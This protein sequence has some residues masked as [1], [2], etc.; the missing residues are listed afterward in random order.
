MALRCP[1][2][3][4]PDALPFPSEESLPPS[5]PVVSRTTR[6]FNPI[7]QEAS[8]VTSPTL[9]RP[10]S[11]CETVTALPP[12]L[13]D[14]L[15]PSW[16]LALSHA[17]RA[18]FF[19]AAEGVGRP[20]PRGKQRRP[21]SGATMLPGAATSSVPSMGL[22]PLL[23]E[24]SGRLGSPPPPSSAT[25]PAASTSACAAP[26]APEGRPL[27]A[28]SARERMAQF[29]TGLRVASPTA[30]PGW[31]PPGSRSR[32]PFTS[33]SSLIPADQCIAP[34]PSEGSPTASLRAPT[35]LS[36]SGPAWPPPDLRA[37]AEPSPAVP[38]A[39]ELPSPASGAVSRDAGYASAPILDASQSGGDPDD[40]RHPYVALQD[41]D[42]AI[43]RCSTPGSESEAVAALVGRGRVRHRLGNT[44][45]ALADFDAALQLRPGDPQA[46]EGAAAARRA[47]AREQLE[48]LRG[49][50]AAPKTVQ[51]AEAGD[52]LAPTGVA[53]LA[54]AAAALRRCPLA[55]LEVVGVAR[56]E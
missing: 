22:P 53:A 14:E 19:T 10:K 4:Y 2:V 1:R 55:S 28:P 17:W 43:K 30:A 35:P 40:P 36:T 13:H 15:L 56:R 27:T 16:T 18:P 25:S 46:L 48:A 20:R 3:R 8:T 54:R 34:P 41:F 29:A 39:A 37:A 12:R 24:D 5:L 45:G 52:S 47:L 49:A 32:R 9:R 7:T 21:R 51:F 38:A 44:E 31:A 50:V 33:E 11:P 6:V 26:E 42:A 23:S